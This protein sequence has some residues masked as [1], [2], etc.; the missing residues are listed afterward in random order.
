[1]K[2]IFTN[3]HFPKSIDDLTNEEKK[4]IVIAGNLYHGE[5]YSAETLAAKEDDEN[6]EEEISFFNLE[7][8]DVIDESNELKY[9]L[10][11]Y[12]VDSGTLFEGESTEVAGEI[13][14]CGFECS[15]DELAELLLKAQK[16]AKKEYKDKELF[17]VDFAWC[18]F[19]W[20][21]INKNK[22]IK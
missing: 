21:I 7:I 9:K 3:V 8:W 22:K 5:E 11:L 2:L 15:D 10:F 4:Q 6:Y 16:E 18:C 13:I 20:W 1:M 12:M 19:K 17:G 14:Q